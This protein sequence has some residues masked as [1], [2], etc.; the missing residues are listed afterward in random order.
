MRVLVSNDPIIQLL[1]RAIFI[2]RSAPQLHPRNVNYYLDQDY[3][4]VD[5]LNLA[6]LAA[7]YLSRNSQ[8]A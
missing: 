8:C 3:I 6:I 1:N 4:I 5:C 2:S 7:H